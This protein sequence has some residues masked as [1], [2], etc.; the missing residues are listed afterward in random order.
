MVALEALVSYSYRARIR[1]ITNLRINIEFSA[2]PNKSLDLL[3]TNDGD[4][5]AFRSFDVSDVNLFDLH[6]ILNCCY[7]F[8]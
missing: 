6:L 4:L 2:S 3:L 1:D 8:T 5:A 7:G